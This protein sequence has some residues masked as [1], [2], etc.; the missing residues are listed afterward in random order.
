[1]W[2]VKSFGNAG[3]LGHRQQGTMT[4]GPDSS[5]EAD[6]AAP[7]NSGGPWPGYSFLVPLGPYP[8]FV[9]TEFVLETKPPP[10]S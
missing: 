3:G 9:V 10:I 4:D 6:G 1:M 2:T 8:V 7:S 5:Q